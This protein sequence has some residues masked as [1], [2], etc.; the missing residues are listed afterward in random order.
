MAATLLS[1]GSH[2]KGYNKKGYNM[3]SAASGAPGCNMS[4][5][6]HFRPKIGIRY[7][8]G[9]CGKGAVC[10]MFHVTYGTI[11][12]IHEHVLSHMYYMIHIVYY[13]NV[14]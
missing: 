13:I 9:A 5:S 8:H 12:Y 11:Y 10:S 2:Q 4:R 1:E 6:F 14:M 3:L 7:T